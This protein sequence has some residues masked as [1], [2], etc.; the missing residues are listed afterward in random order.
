MIPCSDI[1]HSQCV[2]KYVNM[3]LILRTA[4]NLEFNS[5]IILSAQNS[6]TLTD[7]SKLVV[8]PFIRKRKTWMDCVTHFVN[9]KACY[10]VVEKNVQ[11]VQKID[12]LQWCRL[13]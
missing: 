3:F 2:E 8:N 4:S 7:Y 6:S 1:I 11:V 10:G 12:N 5:Y 13:R 9:V